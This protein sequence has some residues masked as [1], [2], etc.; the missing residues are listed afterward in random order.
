MN[1]PGW[2][3]LTLGI[4]LL[5][6]GSCQVRTPV[7]DEAR[8]RE[9]Y[10]FAMATSPDT[11]SLATF[12]REPKTDTAASIRGLWK[13]GRAAMSAT[14][15]RL[16]YGTGPFTWDYG[17]REALAIRRFQRDLGIPATGR[18]DSLTVQHLVRADKAMKLPDVKLPILTVSKS[19][20]FVFARGTWKAITNKL[21]YPVN[22]VNIQC[23][24]TRGE[25]HVVTADF[26]SET[27]DQIALHETDLNIV[28]WSDDLVV[29][30]DGT[31]GDGITLTIN[32]PANEVVW[33]QTNSGWTAP[34][35]GVTFEPSQMTLRLVS[36]MYLAPPFDGGDL[37]Q[38]H[39]ALYG[40]KK[41]YLALLRKNLLYEE[42]NR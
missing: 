16:G 12:A 2:T 35:S 41:R 15:G 33:T 23:D 20:P 18:L 28:H 29:A 36:G 7:D 21:G 32:V 9:A 26:I 5:A 1:G 13:L 40:D 8:L 10:Y 39:E 24:A 31:R 37:K 30:R 38:E 11:M 14:L 27:L 25:C 6:L 17:P 3:L 19:G 22:T 42:E 34:A 4:A